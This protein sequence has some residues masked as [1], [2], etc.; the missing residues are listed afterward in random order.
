[1]RV[2]KNSQW[3]SSAVT[4]LFFFV[5]SSFLTCMQL[6]SSYQHFCS[7][8]SMQ[9]WP[10]ATTWPIQSS[11]LEALLCRW[12]RPKYNPEPF[13]CTRNLNLLIC[14]TQFVIW[15]PVIDQWLDCRPS[16]STPRLERLRRMLTSGNKEKSMDF[17]ELKLP[18]WHCVQNTEE[19]VL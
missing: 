6:L 12:V 5:S 2:F 9:C 14:L 4:I 11:A 19:V 13:S 16:L 17:D 18:A 7:G 10:K 8:W 3:T 15:E 1:M